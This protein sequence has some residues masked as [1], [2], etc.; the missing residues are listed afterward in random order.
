MTSSPRYILAANCPSSSSTATKAGLSSGL[1]SPSES[2]GGRQNGGSTMPLNMKVP[3][4]RPA[5]VVRQTP[6]A[7]SPRNDPQNPAACSARSNLTRSRNN[8]LHPPYMRT[9]KP[10]TCIHRKD[11]QPRDMEITQMMMVR[12]VSRV[13]RAV[14]LTERVTLRPNQLK[15]AMLRAIRMPGIHTAGLSTIWW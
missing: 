6:G 12:Q 1:N 5:N 2:T 13:L 10:R 7:F 11:S 8:L 9:A 3:A 14:A 4:R 15:K